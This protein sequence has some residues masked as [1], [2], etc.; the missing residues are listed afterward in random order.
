MSCYIL[1]SLTSLCSSLTRQLPYNVPF[2]AK[3]ALIEKIFKDWDMYCEK[4]FSFV[5]DATLAALKDCIK[6][7]FGTFRTSLPDHVHV[8]VEDLV[9]RC[10]TATLARIDWMLQLEN[11][12]FTLNDHYFANYREEYLKRYKKAR[13]VRS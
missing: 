11:P 12:P 5:Y 4:C 2:R 6:M 1:G 8:I 13:Q 7:W 3:V 9:E 10:K